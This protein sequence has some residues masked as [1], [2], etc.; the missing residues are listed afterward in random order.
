MSYGGVTPD[1]VRDLVH[2]AIFTRGPKDLHHTA[3]FIGGTDMAA[4]ERLLDGGAQGVLRSDARVG[5]ARL[6]RL[7]HDGRG[8]GG[9]DGC[10]PR[11]RR[12]RRARGGDRRHRTGRACA[13]RGCWPR[14][15][16]EV[17]ITSRRAGR[18]RRCSKRSRQRFGGARPRRPSRWPTP[19]RRRT[20][21]EGAELLVSA[22]PGRRVPG[23]EGARG[24]AAPACASLADLNAVP[25]LGVE[26]VEVT[27]NGGRARR[28]RSSSA[29]SAS[30]A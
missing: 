23:A 28:R 11:R 4:G 12:E 9:Q 22:G 27:D 29:R 6:E 7:E 16:R 1:D 25:P 21:L 5:D 26:G 24:R 20:V 15:A 3:I 30:A 14:P 10:R 18:R 19:R 2:G 17:T 8:G 13:P